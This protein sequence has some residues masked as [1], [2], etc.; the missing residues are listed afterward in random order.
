VEKTITF[1]T[2]LSLMM[3]LESLKLGMLILTALAINSNQYLSSVQYHVNGDLQ[4]QVKIISVLLIT[5][6]TLTILLLEVGT[7]TPLLQADFLPFHH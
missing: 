2:A 1:V 5:F 3:L 6:P 4:K 7:R